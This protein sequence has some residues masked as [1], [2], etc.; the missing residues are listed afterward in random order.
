MRNLPAH[1]PLDMPVSLGTQNLLDFPLPGAFPCHIAH[2]QSLLPAP[3]CCQSWG[4]LQ[5][6]PWDTATFAAAMQLCGQWH[7]LMMPQPCPAMLCQPSSQA[8]SVPLLMG[9]GGTDALWTGLSFATTTERADAASPETLPTGDSKLGQ[10]SPGLPSCRAASKQ[11]IAFLINVNHTHGGSR[12]RARHPLPLL[13]SFFVF[14]KRSCGA[15][16]QCAHK[17]TASTDQKLLLR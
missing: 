15:E 9:T 4:R 11:L 12:R 2:T 3:A 7:C 13:Q 10:I 6:G 14:Q 1:Q 8:S 5:G 17:G 16:T